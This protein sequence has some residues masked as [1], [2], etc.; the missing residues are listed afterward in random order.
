[1]KIRVLSSMTQLRALLQHLRE[2]HLEESNGGD[3]KKCVAAWLENNFITPEELDKVAGLREGLVSP[4]KMVATPRVRA[5]V[6]AH[7]IS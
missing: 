1:M 3:I 7:D 5:M 4:D 6:L 2:K